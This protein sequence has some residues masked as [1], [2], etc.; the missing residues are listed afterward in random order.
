MNPKFIIY[1]PEKIFIDTVKIISKG[2]DELKA[3]P[4]SQEVA[5]FAIQ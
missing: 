3:T 1:P 2:E 5:I 4:S